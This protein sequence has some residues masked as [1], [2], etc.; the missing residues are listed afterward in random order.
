MGSQ[1]PSQGQPLGARHSWS[2]RPT[3]CGT[4][5][6]LGVDQA[7]AQRVIQR[8]LNRFATLTLI[9]PQHPVC[10]ASM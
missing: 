6:V 2:L 5:S 1:N 9:R 8:A 4:L 3:P 7:D 10:E